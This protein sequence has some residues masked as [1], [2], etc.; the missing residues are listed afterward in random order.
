MQQV[1]A[2]FS[3]AFQQ[4]VVN[5][6]TAFIQLETV[7]ATTFVNIITALQQVAV[8]FNVAFTTAT[9]DAAGILNAFGAFIAG[10]VSQLAA[11][12]M[13]I[14]VSMLQAFQTGADNSAGVINTFGAFLVGAV[15]QM[16][17]SFQAIAVAMTQYFQQGADNA[18]GII[19]QLGAFVTSAINQMAS[20]WQAIAVAMTD[21]FRTGANNAAGYID[22]LRSF[23][24]S[25]TAQM[26]SSMNNVV[27]ALRNIGTAAASAQS[28]V[29]S[30][31][32]ELN[33][34]PNIQRTITYTINVVGSVP[35][36]AHGGTATG[37]AVLAGE[38]NR[39]EMVKVSRAATGIIAS[40]ENATAWAGPGGA[41][42]NAGGVIANATL[43]PLGKHQK[44]KVQPG[45]LKFP[46]DRLEDMHR[47]ALQKKMIASATAGGERV[48]V[49]ILQIDGKEITRVIRKNL[50]QDEGGYY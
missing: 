31:A 4:G 16:A 13:Q 45:T 50:M 3:V 38:N 21:A 20:G 36:F 27:T 26:V 37:G 7:A 40:A 22:A 14:A 41:I 8:A 43:F 44:I 11:L 42:A 1:A 30:L 29:A 39:P 24:A 6:Q 19:N 49:I 33:A 18:A 34:L 32:A 10:W 2:A 5:A 48:E 28:Q 25:A 15:Q 17:E 12:W 46:E 47:R 23:I 35:A 9:Q